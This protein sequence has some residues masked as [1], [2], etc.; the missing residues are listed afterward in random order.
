MPFAENDIVQYIGFI[1]EQML[2]LSY[3][4]VDDCNGQ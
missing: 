2:G 4:C 1:R 3:I